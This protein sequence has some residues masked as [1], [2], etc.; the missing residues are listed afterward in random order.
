MHTLQSLLDKAAVRSPTADPKKIRAAFAMAEKAHAGQKRTSGEAYIQHP[1]EATFILLSLQPDEESII[2]CLLH[3]VIED[4]SVTEEDI[5]KEFG[6]EVMRLC[7]DLTKISTVQFKAADRQVEDWRRMLLAMSRDVRVMLIKCADRIHNMQTLSALKK[8]KQ[9]RIAKETISIFAPLAERL[10]AYD[11]KKQLEDLSFLYLEPRAYRSIERRLAGSN[12]GRQAVITRAQKTLKEIMTGVGIDAEIN[13]RTKN[14]F[15]I[16]RKMKKKN[17]EEV[18]DLYDIFALRV[19]VRTNADCYAA[20]GALHSATTPLPSRFKDFIAVPKSN[21]YQSLH[22][23]VAGLFGKG[24]RS[25]P[26]EVQIRTHDMHNIAEYG[27]AAHWAYAEKKK[28]K[29]V[30]PDS[31]QWI[32]NIMTIASGVSDNADFVETLSV[33]ALS[34]RIF[35]LT[36]Q[37]DIKD[38]PEGSTAIDFA[39]AIHTDVGQEMIAAKMNGRIIPLTHPLKN[40][41]VVEVIRKKGSTPR[42]TWLSFART[43][44]ARSKIRAFFNAAGRTENI[45]AGREMI[46]SHL[47]RLSKPILDK[48][49]TLLKKYKQKERSSLERERI[50]E[51]VGSGEVPASTILKEVFA[52]EFAVKKKP[53]KETDEKKEMVQVVIAGEKNIQY[54]LAKCCSPEPGDDIV[55]LVSVGRGAVV[56]GARCRQA[57][58]AASTRMLAAHFQGWEQK[59][60]SVTLIVAGNNR[61]G[62]LR[63]ITTMLVSIQADIIDISM[64]QKNKEVTNTITIEIPVLAKLPDLLQRLEEMEGISSAKW[65]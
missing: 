25:T 23:T 58:R 37:G 15:S 9:Q 8:E 42:R 64:T 61:I 56:H 27:A 31:L 63:D 30:E 1:L 62:L 21:G 28:S 48:H 47:R 20:L 10:G 54:T 44:S 43:E 14:Y 45:A 17:V 2:A 16:W 7:K 6:D 51:R 39:Y 13:G 5:Q 40:G 24:A 22:T 57:A 12:A 59:P 3:D 38:L 53:E 4:T 36:P 52:E 46:N 26:I 35:V 50:L 60:H 55:A 32:Q 41:S 19:I 65:V 29:S 33:D 49:H 18:S 34:E 11:F